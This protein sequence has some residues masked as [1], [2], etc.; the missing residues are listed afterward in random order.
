M[1]DVLKMGTITQSLRQMSD[2]NKRNCSEGR[3]ID[4][5]EV[6]CFIL[7]IWKEEKHKRCAYLPGYSH[8]SELHV[9]LLLVP[10][11]CRNNELRSDEPVIHTYLC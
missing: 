7:Q 8:R 5:V 10:L 6:N 2:V 9:L 1:A 3:S 11:R 4:T